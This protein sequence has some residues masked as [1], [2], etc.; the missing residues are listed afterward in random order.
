M[1][2]IVEQIL[3]L[4]KEKKT[5]EEIAEILFESRSTLYRELKES[6]ISISEIKNLYQDKGAILLIRRKDEMSKDDF[7]EELA[8]YLLCDLEYIW[9]NFKYRYRKNVTAYENDVKKCKKNQLTS[10]EFGLLKKQILFEL[11]MAPRTLK[12][13]CELTNRS[14]SYVLTALKDDELKNVLGGYGRGGMKKGYYITTDKN[15]I[16]I[17]DTWCANWRKSMGYC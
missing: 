17:H 13:L 16:A 9:K 4:I 5:A 11:K 8:Q 3:E 6:G 12:E 7:K 1:K 15:E 10:L 14:R 2:D